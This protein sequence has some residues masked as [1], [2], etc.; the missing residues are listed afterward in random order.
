LR[1]PE[2]DQGQGA[3]APSAGGP[4]GRAPE[5]SL[6]FCRL[7]CR[8]LQMEVATDE[9]RTPI[10]QDTKKGKLRDYPCVR[11]EACVSPSPQRYAAVQI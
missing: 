5:S 8:S 3:R 10:K 6:T 2:R 11:V 9:V 4:A 1:D 7:R